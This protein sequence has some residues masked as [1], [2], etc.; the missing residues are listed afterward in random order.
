LGNTDFCYSGALELRLV[1][2]ISST[3]LV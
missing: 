1:L 2:G 3:A